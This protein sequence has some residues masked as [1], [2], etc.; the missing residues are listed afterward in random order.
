MYI[1]IDILY[2]TYLGKNFGSN[3]SAI[4]LLAL[5]LIIFLPAQGADLLEVYQLARDSNPQVQGQIAAL[6]AAYE[7]K[8]QARAL[9]LP[10]I[11]ISSNFNWNRQ[12]I[13][14]FEHSVVPGFSGSF[15]TY[16]YTLNL[17]QPIY[18][19]D[20]F[21]QLKQ[22]DATIAQAQANLVVQEQA[23]LVQVAQ[24]Y[25]TV[26][27]AQNDLKFARAE[28][29]S[30]GEQLEQA[31]E[32]FKVG[33]AT[34]V[35]ANEAQAAYDL[36][37]SREIVAETALASAHE[38]LREVIGEYVDSLAALE[39]DPPLLQ[40]EPVD[41][42]KWTETA[43]LQNPQIDASEAA[44]DNARQ[45][46][47]L[48]KSGH[49]PTLDIVGSNSQAIT[50]GGRFGGFDTSQDIIGLQLNV[51]IFQGG[52]VVSRTRQ[53]RHQL[54]QA[55]QQLEQVRRAVSRQTREAYLGVMSQL[56]QIKALEQAIVSNKTSL[57][58]AQAGSQVGT[59][60]TVDVLNSRSLLFSAF[61]TH[62]RAQYDYILSTLQLKQGAGIITPEDL[63]QVN[64]WLH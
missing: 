11:G 19:R 60:I 39:K 20:S 62:A 41:I 9:F 52:A 53:A 31:K 63:V 64:K 16:G 51:P 29:K 55:L 40:P 7:A 18:H 57:E 42:N 25:F 54:D 22:A 28:K 33:L 14:L 5:N 48:Q 13:S 17:T 1:Y 3:Q 56:N 61:R 35:D 38:G 45:E 47:K 27:A 37:V 50:G 23:L 24:V 49:Y 2:I 36:A 10:T 30:I 6:Q 21:I 8:P 46:I 4:F 12:T 32:R 34:I 43:L 15:E 44:V 58:S 59:R 26:L